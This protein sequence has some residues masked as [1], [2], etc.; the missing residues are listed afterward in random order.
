MVGQLSLSSYDIAATD[1]RETSDWTI[2]TTTWLADSA[3]RTAG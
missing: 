2:H 3:A 1:Q